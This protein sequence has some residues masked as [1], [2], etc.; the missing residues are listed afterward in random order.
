VEK[1]LNVWTE[2]QI[3]KKYILSVLIDKGKPK[4]VCEYFVSCLGY[5]NDAA[6][7][8]NIRG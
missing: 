5:V 7:F 3:W 8:E 6:G 1:P 4:Y 2:D